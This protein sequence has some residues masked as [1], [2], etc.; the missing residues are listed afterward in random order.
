MHYRADLLGATLTITAP[1]E[2]GTLVRCVLEQEV[3]RA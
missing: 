3:P 1:P 2:G